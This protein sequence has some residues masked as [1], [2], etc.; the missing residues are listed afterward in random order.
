VVGCSDIND[1]PPY[2]GKV[3]IL[4]RKGL[5][6]SHAANEPPGGITA[7]AYLLRKSIAV[8]TT[9]VELTRQSRSQ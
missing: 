1:A 9:A 8:L 2:P 6:G 4:P 3:G 5:T 7:A